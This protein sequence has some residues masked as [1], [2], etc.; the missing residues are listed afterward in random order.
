MRNKMWDYLA[1]G[2]KNIT[3]RRTRSWLTMIGIFIG[4]AAVVALVSL[5]QGMN[6]A[7][8]EQ[9]ELLGIDKITVQPGGMFGAPGSDTISGSLSE[10]DVDLIEKIKGVK[11]A[12]G[13]A[14]RIDA[15]EFEDEVYYAWTMGLPMEKD[16]F[17]LFIGNFDIDAEEGR[18]LKDS[19]TGKIAIGYNYRFKKVFEDQVMVGDKLRIQGKEWEVVGIASQIGNPQ[20][21]TNIYIPKDEY[22]VIYDLDDQVDYLIA[23]VEPGESPGA[24]AKEIE[25]KM[26]KDRGEEIGEESFQVATIEDLIATFN[27]ILGA[28]QAVLIGIAAISLIVGGIGIMNT[29][30]TAVL[31]RTSEIGIMKAIGA[32]NEDIKKIFLVESGLL[33]LVGGAIGI[34]LGLMMAKGVEMLIRNAW[35]ITY[36]KPYFS[37]IMIIGALLFSFLIGSAS[38]Y[39]P[40]KQAA[41]MHPVDAIRYD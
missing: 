3:K 15:I 20:D 10:D 19:D 8:Y 31:E 29:M 1:I 37:P 17:D 40:A 4:I 22:N 13:M 11:L 16:E 36:L 38:G 32:R 34:I 35:G 14:F 25:R 7:I 33:G 26:R 21:D 39:F 9:F 5:G 27:T 30:Y 28:V 18:M 2:C 23:Q 12:S 24:I 6:K 41:N